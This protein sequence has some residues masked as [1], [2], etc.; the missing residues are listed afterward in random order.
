[1]THDL[2]PRSRKPQTAQQVAADELREA[3]LL[4]DLKPGDPVRQVEFA[5]QLGLSRVPVREALKV[6][7][8]EGLL[9]YSPHHGYSV[10]QLSRAE[11]V[12]IYR[13]RDLLE[14]EATR[15]GVPLL[16]EADLLRMEER[17]EAFRQALHEGNLLQ[18]LNANREFHTTLFDKGCT[19]R[20]RKLIR[21]VWDSIEPYRSKTFLDT[22]FHARQLDDH[23]QIIAAL[24][25]G[26]LDA[27]LDISQA[28]R[29]RALESILEHLQ[30]D[31]ELS[32]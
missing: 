13:I 12:E 3:I 16:T 24:R 20:L 7:E 2:M 29:S 10:T 1:M 31:D 15:L 28:H 5:N 18:V 8:G 26:D 23:E 21:V 4:G 32:A 17:N 6:L 25:T 14:N 30:T 9:H 19:E 11:I 27:V 22:T